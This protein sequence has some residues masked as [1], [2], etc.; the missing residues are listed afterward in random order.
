M[1]ALHLLLLQHSSI[2][3]ECNAVFVCLGMTM[4]FKAMLPP[5]QEQGRWLL[6]QPELAM[7]E[8]EI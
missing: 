7:F 4:G 3:S 6:Q 8:S 1:Q 5:L 2:D